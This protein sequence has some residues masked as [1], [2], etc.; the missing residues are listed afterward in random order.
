M[1]QRQSTAKLFNMEITANSEDGSLIL[2]KQGAEAVS[3][4]I[5]SAFKVL[6]GN[7]QWNWVLALSRTIDN[8]WP[9]SFAASLAAASGFYF[10][11][12]FTLS[13]IQMFLQRVFESTFVGRRCVV[14][15]RFSKKY[16]HPSLDSKITL[17]RLNAV[18]SLDDMPICYFISI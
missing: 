16:R 10:F 9:D 18:G 13:D 3:Q 4:D 15:E 8:S 14:K 6:F 12:F 11:Y 2:I 5:I 1:S 17:K 7:R